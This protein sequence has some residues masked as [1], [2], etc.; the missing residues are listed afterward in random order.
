MVLSD[1]RFQDRMNRDDT[2]KA[3]EVMQA[4]VD[5]AEIEYKYT[6][7]WRSTDKFP[8]GPAWS[9]LTVPYRIKPKPR[10]FWLY[11]FDEGLKVAESRQKAEDY[12][13]E[14]VG[15]YLGVIKVR[16]VL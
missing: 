1:C 7:H 6:G 10:E 15:G 3:I 13:C 16:E 5:G 14:Q 12:K 2:K 8:I 11:P 9:W 4:Y